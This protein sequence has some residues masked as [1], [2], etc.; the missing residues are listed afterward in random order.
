MYHL[1]IFQLISFCSYV[2]VKVKLATFVEGDPMA[3]FSISTTPSFRGG[4][5]F[6]PWISPLYP[7]SLPYDPEC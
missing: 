4:R 3:P 6:I 5:Y 1:N 2:K 7:S